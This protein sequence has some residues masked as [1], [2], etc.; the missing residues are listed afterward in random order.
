MKFAES[1]T[2][3]SKHVPALMTSRSYKE[4]K[5]HIE[6]HMSDITGKNINQMAEEE[7]QFMYFK[8]HDNDNNGKLDGLELVKSLLHWHIE[9]NNF[10]ESGSPEEGTTKI[11]GHEELSMLI[12]PILSSDDT[13]FDG[14]I[15]YGE[16]VAAQKSRG[17]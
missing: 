14:F 17:L 10:M 13:N 5:H 6:Y 15:D 12:D 11:F 4:E 8:M 2:D 16:F 9:E 7:M 3:F 1:K